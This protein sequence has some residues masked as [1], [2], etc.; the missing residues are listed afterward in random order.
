MDKVALDQSATCPALCGTEIDAAGIVPAKI[1]LDER[2]VLA[3]REAG[4]R[5][6]LTRACPCSTLMPV[7]GSVGSKGEQ[8]FMVAGLVARS[9]RPM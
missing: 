2:D 5:L 3:I 4:R 9:L 7:A 1:A 8:A 6:A